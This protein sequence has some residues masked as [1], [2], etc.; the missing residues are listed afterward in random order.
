MA[1]NLQHQ[2]LPTSNRKIKLRRFVSGGQTGADSG[3]I[4]V[5]KRLK[6]EMVGFMPRNFG[7]DDGE[8]RSFAAA[9]GLIEG[10]GGFAWRDKANAQLADAVCG[11][12][13][14]QPKTGKGTTKTIN[15]FVCNEYAYKPFEK[16]ANANFLVI[17]PRRK[18]SRPCI[19]FW[20]IDEEQAEDFAPVLRQFLIDFKVKSLMVSGS[21]EATYP[22]ME[23]A[24]AR[25]FL[26]TL[27]E[28]GPT[29]IPY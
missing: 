23:E 19:L 3:P 5:Y 1:K 15:L 26:H 17:P 25:L 16:P 2:V 28:S 22:G 9:H 6:L 21:K 27:A 14:T 24:C 8:G 12:L 10:E 20:D 4:T 29:S 7:R 18:E 13:L 11:F